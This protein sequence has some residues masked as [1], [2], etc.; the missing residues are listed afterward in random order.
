[1]AIE[2]NKNRETNTY[3]MGIIIIVVYNRDILLYCISK[4]HAKMFNKT[5]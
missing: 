2:H 5:H 3:L 4:K 1:M